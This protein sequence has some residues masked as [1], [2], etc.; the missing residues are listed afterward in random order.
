MELRIAAF[1]S[2][3]EKLLEIFRK[4]EDVHTSV[5]SF[6]FLISMTSFFTHLDDNEKALLLP[7][8]QVATALYRQHNTLL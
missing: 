8:V 5:A 7:K 4:G 2:G 6:V 3:D 1:L